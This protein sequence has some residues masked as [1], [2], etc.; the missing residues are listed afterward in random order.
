MSLRSTYLHVAW[1]HAVKIL[2]LLIGLRASQ[3]RLD[4]TTDLT[5]P[6]TWRWLAQLTCNMHTPYLTIFI[7]SYLEQRVVVLRGC[8]TW[9]VCKIEKSKSNTFINIS[10]CLYLCYS[11]SSHLPICCYYN[12]WGRSSGEGGVRDWVRIRVRVKVSFFTSINIDRVLSRVFE[13]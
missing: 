4:V 5:L 12:F 11:L 13:G 7:W 3:D 1:D 10:S 8:K 6:L 9:W 2:G